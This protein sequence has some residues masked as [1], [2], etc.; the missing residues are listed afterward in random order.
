[1]HAFTRTHTCSGSVMHH[2]NFHSIAVLAHDF[3]HASEDFSTHSAHVYVCVYVCM[4][5]CVYVYMYTAILAHD[6]HHA[7]EDFSTHPAHVYVCMYVFTCVSP[8]LPICTHNTHTHTACITHGQS[9]VAGQDCISAS[10]HITYV[11]TSTHTPAHSHTHIECFTRG[12]FLVGGPD[13]HTST[14]M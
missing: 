12:Q 7:S 10:A 8:I 4:Y 5:V 9:L 14:Y 2:L 6:L 13:R 11:R 3:H 1:M